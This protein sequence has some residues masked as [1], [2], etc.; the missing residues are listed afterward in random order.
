MNNAKIINKKTFKPEYFDCIKKIFE[1]YIKYF[2]VIS[3]NKTN[4]IRNKILMYQLFAILNEN[5]I[6]NYEFLDF[7]DNELSRIYMFCN[8]VLNEGQYGIDELLNNGG[9]KNLNKFESFKKIKNIEN[10]NTIP[11]EMKSEKI[12]KNI[13]VKWLMDMKFE[14]EQKENQ[15]NIELKKIKAKY[16]NEIQKLQKEKKEELEKETNQIKSLNNKIIAL[17]LESNRKEHEY[18]EELQKLMNDFINSRKKENKEMIESREK[19]IKNL[20]K[21]LEESHQEE[22]KK[23]K[24]EAKK[25][26]L[27]LND[28][29]KKNKEQLQKT[30]EELNKKYK[31]KQ[32][33]ELKKKFEEEQ[34]KIKEKEKQINELYKKEIE[35]LKLRE[36]EKMLKEYKERNDFFNLEENSTFNNKKIE[37]LV[38]SLLKDKNISKIILNKL[39]IYIQQS[40]SKIEDIRHLNIL[41]VGPSGVGKST[42]INSIL[43]LKEGTKTG[44]GLP[45]TTEIK[46]FS[47]EESDFLRLYDSRGIEKDKNVGVDEIYNSL[48]TFILNQLETKNPNNYI[49]CIWYCWQGTRLEQS[50]VEI[51]KKLSNQY[52]YEDLPAIIVYTNAIDKEQIKQAED[53]VKNTYELKNEMIHVLAKEKLVQSEIGKNETIYPFNLDKLKER[54]IELANSAVISSCYEGLIN[55][56]KYHFNEQINIFGEKFKEIFKSKINDFIS[57]INESIE[58]EKVYKV[59]INAILNLLLE[60]IFLDLEL[61]IQN[62]DGDNIDFS[63]EEREEKK[64]NNFKGNYQIK[65]ES[66]GK[67]K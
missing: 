61:N 22:I 50:E 59:C 42:L 10:E 45:Q 2:D 24:E 3:E 43:E 26:E 21:K 48:K 46:S 35:N 33:E 67:K 25:M 23:L 13:N 6:L 63:L 34:R 49:H 31:E 52:K 47:S 12:D 37:C 8:I 39:N 16:K 64:E 57:I 40:K 27:Q 30:Y 19:Q 7:I 29:E 58:K 15:Y 9:W 65:E 17:Q 11:N 53:L 36:I 28:Q 55:D 60:Y 5:N 44:I 51:I 32:E 54:S 62:L 56:I 18:K 66:H 1:V 14:L 38:N 4:K 20:Q 41:L